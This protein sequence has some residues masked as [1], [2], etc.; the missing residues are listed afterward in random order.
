MEYNDIC[1]SYYKKVLKYLAGIVGQ[2]EAE[3]LTQEVFIK[4]DKSLKDLKDPTKLSPWIF[5]VALNTAKDRLRRRANMKSGQGRKSPA[6]T[7]PIDDGVIT[8]IQDI[9]A[10]TPEE[11]LIYSKM[12]EC[13]MEFVEKL[14]KLYIDVYVLSELDGF[15]DKE[16]SKKL[17]L[18][19]ETVKMRLH[20]ART[21][22]YK[23]LRSHC[24]CY[25]NERG[26]LMGDLK[27]T[28][29]AKRS[30]S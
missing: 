25:Y 24:C 12:I 11:N 18:P 21:R 5:A 19:L 20:R 22:L 29:L 28:S 10:R 13:F 7:A 4:I 14:P 3:D 8:R 27:P 23:E 16:I 6:S 17:S 9:R 15:S 1:K 26:E 30:R 2:S